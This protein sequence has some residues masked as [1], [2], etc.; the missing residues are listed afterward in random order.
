MRRIGELILEERKRRG[1][2]RRH[3]AHLAGVPERTL[4]D[5]EHGHNRMGRENTVAKVLAVLEMDIA[6]VP[7]D[8]AG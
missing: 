2:T 3:L 4:Y 5:L 8:M 1:W 7:I 6:L